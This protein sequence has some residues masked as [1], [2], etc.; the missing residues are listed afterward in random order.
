MQHAFEHLSGIAGRGSA[1]DAERRAAV[2]LAEDLYQRGHD[3]WLE[4]VWLRPRW[5]AALALGA[6]L[7]AAGSLVSVAV[8]LAGLIAAG[9]AAVTL[10]AE[11]LGRSSPLRAPARRRATQNVVSLPESEDV[12]LIVCAPYSAPRRGM[13]LND[14]WRA[15]AARLGDVRGWLAGGALLVA[16]TAALRLAGIDAVWVGIVQLVPTVALITA[17]AAALDIALSEVSPGA[18]TASAAAVALAVHDELVREPPSELAVGLV[19]YGAADAGSQALR[20]RLRGAGARTTVLLELGPCTGGSPGYRTRHSQVRRAAERAAA[21]LELEPP[22]RRLRPSR[23]R[24]LP[25]IRIA[26]LDERGIVA[27]SHQPD[28]TARAADAGAATAALDLALGVADALDA[29]LGARAHSPAADE[30]PGRD[31]ALRG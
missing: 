22:P 26:C 23:V 20:D 24:R 6:F 29:E 1:T 25:A 2:W 17:L 19:L 11:A 14:R 10:A 31:R 13:L 12:T 3:A 15:A 21:A 30:E 16:A 28:D 27:R 7:A 18:D 5:A 8:P 4:P 9:V